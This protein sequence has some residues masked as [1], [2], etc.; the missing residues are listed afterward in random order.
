MT[1]K[2]HLLDARKLPPNSPFPRRPE[3]NELRGI[4]ELVRNN[5]LISPL[6]LGEMAG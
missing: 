2:G 6:S 1:K 5:F 4:S 3:F